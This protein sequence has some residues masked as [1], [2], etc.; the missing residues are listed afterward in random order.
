MFSLYAIQV[1]STILT[2]ALP[3]IG[4][5]IGQ[6]IISK[7]AFDTFNRQ[8]HAI[9]ILSRLL[10]MTL[11]LTETAAILSLVITLLLLFSEPAVPSL[12]YLGIVAAVALPGFIIGLVSAFP[13]R[14]ALEAGAR[15][16]F[17]TAKIFNLLLITMI[18]IQTPIIFGFIIAFFIRLNLMSA[19]T[20]SETTKLIMSG[21][22]LGLG[23]LGPTIGLA[24]FASAACQALGL[25]KTIYPKLLTFALTSQALIETPILFSFITALILAFMPPSDNPLMPVIY[26]AAGLVTGLSMVGTGIAS[27]RTAASACKQIALQPEHYLTLSRAS[28]LG[29]AFID[30]SAV[31]GLIIALLLLFFV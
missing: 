19:L 16:P 30:T 26:I 20:T 9:N 14:E 10:Y 18:V 12:A 3:S 27:G 25:N 22:A 5:S 11:A 6:G 24:T 13:A 8:P 23:S 28:M 2:I 29:Q 21:I 4:V 31:Y 15:Q 1:L 7:S 17:S